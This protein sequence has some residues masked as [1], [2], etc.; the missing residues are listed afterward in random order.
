MRTYYATKKPVTVMVTEPVTHENVEEIRDWIGA[1]TH[2]PYFG[3]AD[4]AFTIDTLEGEMYVSWG[5]RIIKGVHGEFYAIKPDIFLASY[6]CPALKI[7]A[8]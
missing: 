4:Y 6:D 8:Y 5:D 3:D 1:E 7:R 2:L